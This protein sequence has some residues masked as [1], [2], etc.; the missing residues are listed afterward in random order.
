MFLTLRRFG[1]G[2]LFAR[3]L[4]LVIALSPSILMAASSVSNDLAVFT[5]GAF[6]L[7]AVV[8]LM[9]R[10]SIGYPHLLIGAAIG[11][12]GGL[13]KPS[14]LLVVCALALGLRSS[15]SGGPAG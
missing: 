1:V 5:F 14:A 8:G 12:I 4:S 7:W 10:P 11:V 15:S 2:Q 6:A 9:K 3:V 13:I